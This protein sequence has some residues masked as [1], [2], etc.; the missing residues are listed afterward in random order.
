MDAKKSKMPTFYVAA[1]L[2]ITLS[3]VFMTNDE[4]SIAGPGFA[5]VFIVAWLYFTLSYRDQNIP[6]FDVGMFCALIT[7]LYSVYPLVNYWVGGFDFGILGDTRLATY[8]PNPSEVGFF[9][10][11]HVVYLFFLVFF[12]SAFRGKGIV[13]A[14]NFDKPSR[15]TTQIVISTFVILTGYFTILQLTTGMNFNAGYDPVAVDKKM[16]AIANAPLILIQI[17]GKLAGILTVFKLALLCL[18]I[19]RCKQ[20]KWFVILILWIA[21]EIIQMIVIKG[22]RGGTFLFI[23][24]AFLLYHRIIKA[25][26]MKFLILSGIVLFASFTFLGLYRAYS[27]ISSL[28]SDYSQGDATYVSGTNNEFQA[29]LGTAYDVFQRKNAGADIPWYLYLNDVMNILPPQQL[30]PFEKVDASEWYLREIG[31]SGTGQGFMWGVITQSIVGF[32][33]IELALR[34]A[35]LGY[36]LGRIHRWYVKNQSG[37]L[38]TLFYLYLCIN[39]FDTFRNTTGSILTFVFWEVVPFY[40]ILRLGAVIVRIFK[41]NELPSRLAVSDSH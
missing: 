4:L 38:E 36:F 40:I 18:V 19:N 23:L 33:W 3:L 12:Y 37:F 25:F 11:R 6:V 5:C 39:M 1:F 41:S 28:N 26:S 27:D 14:G 15:I 32:D 31:F 35:L 13:V 17:S 34:G 21:A 22:A 8:K 16:T 29:L 30:L 10:W 20:K 2:I 9:H 7:L 24:A